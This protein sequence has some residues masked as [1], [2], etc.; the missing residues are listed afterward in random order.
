MEKKDFQEAI[1]KE[2]QISYEGGEGGKPNLNG[3]LMS[4][5]IEIFTRPIYFCTAKNSSLKLRVKIVFWQI[6]FLHFS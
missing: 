2:I 4:T 3:M 5:V 1:L 6:N